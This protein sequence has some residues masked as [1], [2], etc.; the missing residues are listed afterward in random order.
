MDEPVLLGAGLDELWPGVGKGGV[1][2]AGGRASLPPRSVARGPS[3]HMKAP[4]VL[5]YSQEPTFRKNFFGA[6]LLS[7]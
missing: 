3:A 4:G 7:R 6:S 1:T 5:H 2:D